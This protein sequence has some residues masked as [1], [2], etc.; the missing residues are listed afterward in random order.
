METKCHK[1]TG[2][3]SG[4]MRENVDWGKKNLL[5]IFH[6]LILTVIYFPYNIF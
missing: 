3:E 5:L 6:A 2:L 1:R 4:K